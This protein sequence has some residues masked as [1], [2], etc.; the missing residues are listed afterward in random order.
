VE[1]TPAYW[2]GIS[3]PS[4][5]SIASEVVF[6]LS[7]LDDRPGVIVLE[8]SGPKADS[9][10]A[11]EAGGHR[12]QRTPPT[13]KRGRVQ[14]STITVAVLPIIEG[15]RVGLNERDIEWQATRGS[16]KGGQNRNKTST[17]VIMKH[18]PTGISVRVEA[19]RSQI[20]NRQTA[21]RLLA[22]KI[23]TAERE[24]RTSSEAAA[25]KAQLGVGARGDK[26]RTIRMQDDSVI[27]HVTGGRM[28]ASRYL[29]GFV[30]ELGTPLAK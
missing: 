2:C 13:E 24:K 16:G 21:L 15:S 6:S 28:R 14:T 25:R 11:N 4:I 9:L 23:D 22:S 26:R 30:D 8:I 12:W 19:E 10:F 3:L 5:R 7:I 29:K 18:K 17:A 27:D 20:Q 1:K